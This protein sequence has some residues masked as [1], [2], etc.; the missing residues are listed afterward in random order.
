[1]RTERFSIDTSGRQVIDVT[2]HVLGFARESGGDGLLSVFVPHATAGLALMETGAGS[3]ADLVEA[4]ERLL[5]RDDRYRHRHGSE[6]HGA[7]HLIP[8]FVSSSLVLPVLDGDVVLGTWQRV[9][10]LDT[11]R[12]NNARSLVVSFLSD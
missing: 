1:M 9:V 3:E 7:D 4:I 11:N 12:E 5:P 10:V 6:G 2:E 8:A